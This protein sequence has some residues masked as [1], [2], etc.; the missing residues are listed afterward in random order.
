MK[1]LW[2]VLHCTLSCST[3]SNPAQEFYH[4]DH[5]TC[6]LFINTD[7]NL[8]TDLIVF[9]YR[10]PYNYTETYGIH[11]PIILYTTQCGKPISVKL[12]WHQLQ[13]IRRL[14]ADSQWRCLCWDRPAFIK[15]WGDIPTSKDLNSQS[16]GNV[17]LIFNSPAGI[18][19]KNS[20]V[21]EVHKWDHVC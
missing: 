5:L 18:G 16:H 15:R 1:L 3:C 6:S 20:W 19:Q 12:Y 9:T 2:A 7:Y 11:I 14:L 17:T 13:F 8:H 10:R 4:I 21:I